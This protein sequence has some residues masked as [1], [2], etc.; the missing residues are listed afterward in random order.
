MKVAFLFPGQGSQSVGMGADLCSGSKAALSA[1]TEADTL[2]A[3][4]LSTYC[5]YGPEEKL[6]STEIA[7]PALYASSIAAFRALAERG[8]APEAVA[9]HSV[10]EYSALCAAGAFDFQTGLT[11]VAQRGELMRQAGAKTPG[12]MAAVLGLEADAVDS[13]CRSASEVGIVDVANYNGAGQVVISGEPDAVEAASA[14]CR[15]LGARRVLPIPVSGAFHSPLMEPA[16]AGMA[17]Y[18]EQATITAPVMPV[19]SNVTADV[20]REPGQIR[21]NLARQI[22][23]PVRWEQIMKRLL[24]DRFDTFIE[25][26]S[27]SVLTGLTRRIA[28]EAKT[29][30]VKDL[31]GL[32]EAAA[33]LSGGVDQGNG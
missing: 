14:R 32:E 30:S 1:F 29:A 12:T 4:K 11:L 2:L 13:A 8:F 6:R 5:F 25:L 31:A 7:Q 10:G 27:G 24:A 21:Q 15:E 17:A 18:L 23:A 3:Y 19:F 22:A 20:Q 26:G 33:L 9:G 16:V 28:P